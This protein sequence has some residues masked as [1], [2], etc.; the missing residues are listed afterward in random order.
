MT[1]RRICS[2]GETSQ[3]GTFGT[4]NETR[5]VSLKRGTRGRSGYK[6]KFRMFSVL[7]KYGIQRFDYLYLHFSNSFRELS[8]PI[9]EPI[10]HDM[11]AFF[12]FYFLVCG[13]HDETH[14][15][16]FDLLFLN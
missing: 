11:R 5:R 2:F 16:V 10:P 12:I 6:S 3:S 14:K 7:P 15:L 4:Q 13:S 9:H 1:Y 8:F